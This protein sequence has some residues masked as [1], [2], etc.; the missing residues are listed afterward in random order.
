MKE[1]VYEAIQKA[2]KNGIRLRDIGYYCNCWH[3]SCLE[4]VSALID[5]DKVVGKTIGHGWE[6]YIK[7][8]VKGE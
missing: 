1:K 2:G 5:E 4:H 6:A 8:Y 7:Y 3:C